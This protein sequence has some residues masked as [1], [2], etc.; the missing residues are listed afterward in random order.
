MDSESFTHD[1]VLGQWL[2][3][4]QDS[5]PFKAQLELEKRFIASCISKL[6][7]IN[8]DGINVAI[9]YVK[10]RSELDAFKKMQNLRERLIQNRNTRDPA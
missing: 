7:S 9:D 1:K 8:P 10:V 3:E 4:L 2:K 5:E 6:Q